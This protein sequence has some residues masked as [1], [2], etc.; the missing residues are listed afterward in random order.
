MI[1]R[2]EKPCFGVGK[3][4][5]KQ[6]LTIKEWNDLDADS[7]QWFINYSAIFSTQVYRQKTP[8]ELATSHKEFA[9]S[10]DLI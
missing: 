6:V 9:A 10:L 7:N 1:N 4:E 2:T 3:C 8:T 5:Y